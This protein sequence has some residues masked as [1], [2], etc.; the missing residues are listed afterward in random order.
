[1][2]QLLVKHGEI[3]FE[4][5]AVFIDGTKI[6]ANAGRY[7]FIWKTRVAKSQ[8]K[9]GEKIAKELPGLLE[10]SGAGIRAPREITV[11]RLKKLRKQLYAAKER[12]GIVLSLIHI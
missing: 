1:M 5:S 4:K 10:K 12:M 3:S 9:L 11:Q 2:V 7:T 6:E 8:M